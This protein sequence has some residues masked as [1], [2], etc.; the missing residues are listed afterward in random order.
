MHPSA[1]PPIPS[2]QCSPPLV[3]PVVPAIAGQGNPT[4]L[5]PAATEAL[6]AADRAEEEM[7]YPNTFEGPEKLLEMWFKPSLAYVGGGPSSSADPATLGLRCVPREQWVV[8]LNLV[9]CEVLN[10]ISAGEVEAFLL[11]ESSLFVYPHKVILKTCGTTTLLHAVPELL[12]LAR[13][14][15]GWDHLWRLFYSRKRFM[16]PDRQPHPHR[17]WNHEVTFLD[18]LFANGSAYTVGRTNGDHWNLYL[19][20]PNPVA[21]AYSPPSSSATK[22]NGTVA[23]GPPTQPPSPTRGLVAHDHDITVEILMTELDPEA[24]RHFHRAHLPLEPTTTA[25]EGGRLVE[26][27]T[28]ISRIY[29]HARTDSYLF[30]P[31]G[32]SL[33]GLTDDGH[34]FTIHVTPE[35]EC[36]YAS[37]ETNLRLG[38]T[39]RGAWEE[40]VEAYSPAS[41]AQ[42]LKT[43]VEQ[44]T[45]IFRPGKFSA[46][47]F[48]SHNVE[49]VPSSMMPPPVHGPSDGAGQRGPL[50][51]DTVPGR[52]AESGPADL[53]SQFEA[54]RRFAESLPPWNLESLACYRQSDHI[55]YEFDNYW[56]RF[57]YFTRI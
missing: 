55:M 43:L 50:S 24:V 57:G 49:K 34:Y 56:L 37:F 23:S 4:D 36:S 29:P 18:E 53:Q 5:P 21:L 40:E 51:S 35:P 2:D 12:R 19:T 11:S 15:C 31:C 20:S 28:G 44:V 17:D 27:L 25:S 13:E 39:G 6:A 33:N 47:V 48:K 42:A 45:D 41:A 8:M 9:H 46:T 10:V 32:F 52:G 30:T 16:F 26:D 22:T 7:V 54:W 38:S 3:S 1:A 14:V